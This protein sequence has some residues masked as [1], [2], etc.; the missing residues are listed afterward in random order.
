M[1]KPVWAQT[2]SRR[3]FL[4]G[5]AALWPWCSRTFAENF[6]HPPQLMTA[7]SQYVILDPLVP[8]RPAILNTLDGKGIAFPVPGRAVRLV[9]LWATW[10][11]SCRED[12]LELEQFRRSGTAVAVTSISVDTDEPAKV[13]NFMRGIGIAKPQVMIDPAGKVAARGSGDSG[14][15]RLYGLPITYLITP[16]GLIAGYIT[17]PVNWAAPGAQR[18]IDYYKDA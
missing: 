1:P 8:L 13:K 2:I 3:H 14:Q 17:G 12:L 15:L 9:H 5:L 7:S 4:A 16:S 10:C 18:L 11:P 6:D